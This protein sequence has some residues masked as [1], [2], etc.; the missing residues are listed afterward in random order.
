[1]LE[2]SVPQSMTE[3]SGWQGVAGIADARRV[4]EGWREANADGTL[5]RSFRLFSSPS[6][7]LTTSCRR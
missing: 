7:C 1:M 5:R 2:K 3:F 4:A 6:G